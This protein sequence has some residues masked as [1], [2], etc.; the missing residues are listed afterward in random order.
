MPLPQQLHLMPGARRDGIFAMWYGKGPGVDRCGDVFRHANHAGTS[1]HGGVLVVAGDD[2]AA[3]SSAVAHQSEHVFSACAIPVLAPA[4]V[5]DILDFGLHGWAMSRYCGC[6]VAL[7][8]S[9]DVVES[10]ATVE[11]DAARV[12]VRTPDFALPADGLH[13][14]WPDPQLAQEQRMQAYKI[15]AAVAYARANGLD[16]LVWD[17]PGARL[18]LVA[19]GKAWLDLREALH[20]LGIDAAAAARLGLRV[21]KVGMPWPLEAAGAR[22]FA[23]GLE[24]VLVVEEKRQIIE[25][26][27]KEMLYDWP[28]ARRP[29]V[30]GKFDE[31]GEWP[32]PPHQWLLP[33][34]GEMTPAVV[35]RAVAARLARIDPGGAWPQRAQAVA[36]PA[37]EPE[38]PAPAARPVPPPAPKPAPPVTTPPPTVATPVTPAPPKP[39]AEP[40]KPAVAP[41]RPAAETIKPANFLVSSAITVSL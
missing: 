28:D 21:Y 5:Q 25:Y 30:L 4:S 1:R 13:I 2:H 12:A 23:D 22:R 39:A 9:A 15:Y 20:A 34:T 24:E 8:L 36:G 31:T 17:S 7:K 40:I 26:Q 14:R 32:A 3:R 37:P 27:L 16:R 11:I 29:R 35:A 10:A 6:W 33:P 19:C 41:A 38:A 18:G